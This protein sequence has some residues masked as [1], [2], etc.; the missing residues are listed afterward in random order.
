MDYLSEYNPE[1]P[2]WFIQITEYLTPFLNHCL[3][4]EH[5]G[6]TSVPGMVAKPIID[7]DVVVLDGSMASAI[8]SIER[9]GYAHEGDKGVPGREAF[10]PNTDETRALP[11]HHLYA[12]EESAEHL[13]V[14][15][16]FR[17]YLRTHPAEAERLSQVK[18]HLAFERGLTRSEYIEAKEATVTPIAQEALRWY[19]QPATL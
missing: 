19:N 2:A 9:A 5:V 1:W 15:L 6:S 7:I 12:C 18:R 11:H 16:S 8:A 17:D 14:H 4:I 13:R 10:K 3:R